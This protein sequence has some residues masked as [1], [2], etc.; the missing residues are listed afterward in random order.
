M[1]EKLMASKSVYDFLGNEHSSSSSYTHRRDLIEFPSI[2]VY[3]P[4]YLLESLMWVPA[5]MKPENHLQSPPTIQ[6][7]SENFFSLLSLLI[8]NSYLKFFSLWFC[9]REVNVAYFHNKMV[10]IKFDYLQIISIRNFLCTVRSQPSRM[11]W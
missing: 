10:Y 3:V 1:V 9:E 11:S 4:T 2:S 5:E 8:L 7:F 6:F